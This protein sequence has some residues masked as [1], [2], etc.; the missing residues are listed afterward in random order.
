M[1]FGIQPNSGFANS[2]EFGPER[3]AN[4]LGLAVTYEISFANSRIRP[5]SGPKELR[6]RRNRIPAEERARAGKHPHSTRPL[7]CF[8]SCG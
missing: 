2:A 5:N 4:P 7:H 8:I 3:V 6:T 1:R